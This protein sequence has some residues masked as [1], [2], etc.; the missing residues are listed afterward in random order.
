MLHLLTLTPLTISHDLTCDSVKQLYQSVD[1]TGTSCCEGRLTFG[2]LTC[3]TS[4]VVPPLSVPMSLDVSNYVVVGNSI[5]AGYL[6]GGLFKSGMQNSLP[7]MLARQFEKA[8]GRFPRPF[9]QALVNNNYGGLAVGGM[10]ILAQRLILDPSGQAPVEMEAFLNTTLPVSAD[11]LLD[12]K[13][14]ELSNFAVPGA[15]SF[16]Y[17]ASGYG[18]V[19]NLETKTANPYAVRLTGDTPDKTMVELAVDR[20]PTF[21][22]MTTPGGNDVLSFATGGGVNPADL[23]PVTMFN[24]SMHSALQALTASGS[25]GVISIPGDITAFPFFTTVTHMP[26]PIPDAGTATAINEAYSDYNSALDAAATGGYMTNDEAAKRK[27]VFA[28]GFNAVV[29]IDKHLTTVPNLPN[30]RQTTKDDFVLLTAA[31]IIG[32]KKYP[33]DLQSPIFGVTAPMEDQ[34][35][36]SHDEAMLMKEFSDQHNQ[37]LKDCAKTYDLAFVDF[38]AKFSEVVAGGVTFDGVSID[39]RYISGGMFSLDGIHPTSKGYAYM[40]R[41]ILAAIDEK[42]GSNFVASG[43]VPQAREYATHYDVHGNP[44]DI[45]PLLSFGSQS[46]RS[47]SDMQSRV[48]TFPSHRLLD[49]TY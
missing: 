22:S 1:T 41:L 46:R 18:N 3:D 24:T 6:D 43:N 27:I 19:A 5:E 14:T 10:R 12:E 32:A 38:N 34:H 25:K 20:K 9:K 39:A 33:S 49:I 29:M 48:T 30:I 2:D 45:W 44:F 47:L 26:I 7:A 15:K 37:I 36:L 8:P 42:Y 40:A 17:V 4:Q 21:F 11:L 13:Q 35:I 23:T 28:Q 31:G 16:H